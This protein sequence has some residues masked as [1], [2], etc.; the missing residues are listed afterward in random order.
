M[1]ELNQELTEGHPIP[2]LGIDFDLDIPPFP[3]RPTVPSQWS[4]FSDPA[5]LCMEIRSA[6]N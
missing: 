2:G 4:K 6:W 1:S 3:H 5:D